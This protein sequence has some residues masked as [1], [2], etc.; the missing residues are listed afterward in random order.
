M[1][2]PSNVLHTR[3]DGQVFCVEQCGDDE[4]QAVYPSDLADLSCMYPTFAIAIAALR[5]DLADLGIT[6]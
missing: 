1:S 5:S 3:A 6:A 2:A 4:F